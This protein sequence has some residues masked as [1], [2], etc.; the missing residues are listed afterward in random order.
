MFFSKV[1]HQQVIDALAKLRKSVSFVTLSP[2]QFVE[3]DLDQLAAADIF[4]EADFLRSFRTHTECDVLPL[5]SRDKSG[6]DSIMQMNVGI[7][8][9]AFERVIDSHRLSIL[10]VDNLNFFIYCVCMVIKN[11][12][13][14]NPYFGLTEQDEKLLVTV[15]RHLVEDAPVSLNSVTEEGAWSQ[16]ILSSTE[17]FLRLRHRGI[18]R[19]GGY[20]N[21]NA[22]RNAIVEWGW[23]YRSDLCHDIADS[24][25]TFDSLTLEK[26]HE[27]AHGYLGTYLTTMLM[28]YLELSHASQDWYVERA[29]PLLE[30]FLALCEW[31]EKM[32]RQALRMRFTDILVSVSGAVSVSVEKVLFQLACSLGEP[33]EFQKIIGS[34]SLL[35]LFYYWSLVTEFARDVYPIGVFEDTNWV[36]FQRP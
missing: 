11:G 36:I 24:I 27:L 29:F 22:M 13:G 20:I 9:E 23:I 18:V 16:S 12:Q 14:M 10:W 15:F 21:R 33:K 7:F 31:K 5:L 2:R 25:N 17:V 3:A 1:N 4:P 32:D 26:R 28:Q 30:E 35:D 34:Y 19:P 8:S 6:F